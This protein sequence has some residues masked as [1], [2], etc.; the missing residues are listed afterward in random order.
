MGAEQWEQ[1]ELA[2]AS[3]LALG[4]HLTVTVQGDVFKCV[5]V[6]KYLSIGTLHKAW[7]TQANVW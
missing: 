4:H 5:K 1:W 2:V 6:F 3:A 7:G